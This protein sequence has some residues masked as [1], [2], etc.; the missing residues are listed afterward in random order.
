MRESISRSIYNSM[1]LLKHS[2][3]IK[4]ELIIGSKL[5]ASL[6]NFKETEADG[7]LKMLEIY[8]DALKSEIGIAYN[9]TKDQGFIEILNLVSDLNLEDHGVSMWKIAKA[10]ST[11]TTIA[12]KA[13]QSLFDNKSD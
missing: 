4:S 2:E 6:E 12:S 11:T 5:L 1:N 3:R 13:Y 9:S 8:F 10:V 7:A